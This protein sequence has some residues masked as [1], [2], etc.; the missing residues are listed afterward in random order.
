[1]LRYLLVICLSAVTFLVFFQ[2]IFRN[3]EI[4]ISGFEE[5]IGIFAMW[6]YFM[7]MAHSTLTNSHIKGGLEELINN[8]RVRSFLSKIS[9]MALLLFS[10]ISLLV[11]VQVF[12]TAYIHDYV[13]LYFSIPITFSIAALVIGFAL[14]LVFLL[15]ELVGKI[16]NNGRR[17]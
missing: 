4:S 1:M 11:S 5:L 12:I 10:L 9:F 14:N 7:G 17:V 2:F 6:S 3:T 8:L 13:T 16:K 15:A